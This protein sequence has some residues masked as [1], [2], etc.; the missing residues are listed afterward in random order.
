MGLCWDTKTD[1]TGKCHISARYGRLQAQITAHKP[2]C[3]RRRQMISSIRVLRGF[4]TML[5]D[6]LAILFRVPVQLAGLQACPLLS[7]RNRQQQ[8]LRRAPIVVPTQPDQ[9]PAVHV[10][11]FS[12]LVLPTYQA[13][14]LKHK[15][16]KLIAYGI[17]LYF[18]LPTAPDSIIWASSSA[19]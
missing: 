8:R 5:A 18:T 6:E 17:L 11:Q 15:P 13:K 12:S 10:V 1:D 14:F 7:V 9:M 2:S 19:E 3:R 16:F 4:S